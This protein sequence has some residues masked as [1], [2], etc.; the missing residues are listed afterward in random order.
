MLPIRNHIAALIALVP[1]ALVFAPGAAQA[2][3]RIA[4]VVGN[5]GYQAGA[6]N[7]PANDAGLIA[8]TLQAAGFDVVGARD[9]DQDSMRHAFRDFLEKATRAGADTVAFVYVSGYG[10]QLEG[11]NYFVPVDARIAHDSDVAAEALR[12]SDYT[13]PLA[14]L[15]LKASIVVLDAARANP[16]AKS[17]PP[18]AGGLALV[19]PEPS[20]LI[21]FN[22]APGTVAPEGQAPYGAYA[23]A[24][25]EMIREGGLPLPGVFDRARLRVNEMT[26]GAEV[27]WHASKVQASLVFFER[28]ADAPPPTVSVEETAAIRSRPIRDL[29]AQDAY[30]LALERDTIEGYSDFLAAYPDDPMAPRVRAIIAARREAITWRRTRVVDTPPAYWSYLQ[31]YPNGPHA[32]D[33]H[34]RL[35]YLAAAFEPPPTFAVVDYDL[36]PRFPLDRRRVRVLRLDPM[37]RPSQT[38]ARVAPLRHDAFEAKLTGVMEYDRAVVVQVPPLS[39]SNFAALRSLFSEHKQTRHRRGRLVCS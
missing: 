32:G 15:K 21:A 28:A 5:A 23:Q 34:R 10:V 14:A 8:Q 39:R 30:V 35:A 2:E 25:A 20:L 3:K 31:R 19:E 4:L 22:A 11:E 13:R 37:R 12:L 16:F 7:T 33:A 36:P 38:I 1:L 26:Q 29:G 6:L 18:L 27:P 24:L 17:G 9:L